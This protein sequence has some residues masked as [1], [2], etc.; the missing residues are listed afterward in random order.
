MQP[1]ALCAYK[2]DVHPVFDSFDETRRTELQVTDHELVCPRWEAEMLDGSLPASQAL[3]DRL[4]SAGYV[5]VLVPSFAVGAGPE[6]LNLVIWK[7]G[8]QRPYRVILIDDERR[9]SSGSR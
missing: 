1:L 9:R 4:I 7:W 5:G 8:F 2:V 3:A 6:D